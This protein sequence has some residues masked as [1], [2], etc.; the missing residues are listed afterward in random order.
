MEGA[1]AIVDAHA[2]CMFLDPRMNG[3]S[4]WDAITQVKQMHPG[5]STTSTTH[6]DAMPSRA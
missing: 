6:Y 2:V 4:M 3:G 5:W 1:D